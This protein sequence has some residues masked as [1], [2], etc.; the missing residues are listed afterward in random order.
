MDYSTYLARKQQ[1][2]PQLG[3]AK[4][5]RTSTKSVERRAT[6]AA[7][8]VEAR[9]C[10]C[11][12][13]RELEA[14][15]EHEARAILAAMRQDEAAEDRRASEELARF[16]CKL[17]RAAQRER[18][19]AAQALR[20][21]RHREYLA[22]CVRRAREAQRQF[23]LCYVAVPVGERLS[24]PGPL[25]QA[26]PATTVNPEAQ[27]SRQPRVSPAA[28]GQS[29]RKPSRKSGNL[30]HNLAAK[31]VTALALQPDSL[32]VLSAEPE[33]M[34]QPGARYD[35]SDYTQPTRDGAQLSARE[36]RTMD[37]EDL[38]L[39]DESQR[40][41]IAAIEEGTGSVHLPSHATMLAH[42]CFCGSGTGDLNWAS[43][44]VKAN[45][46]AAE[47]APAGSATPER[48]REMVIGFGSASLPP[49]RSG[50]TLLF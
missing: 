19:R 28:V 43:G 14:H 11:P 44:E 47:G 27:T 41:E 9:A 22:R 5:I 33:Q 7:A 38:N 25:V 29:S 23:S 2:V 8:L 45:V 48:L 10:T 12:V 34:D 50:G 4:S 42:A 32:D 49:K 37:R 17:D 35:V 13:D 3:S 31:L 40:N 20:A 16:T 36:D 39:Y 1:P 24:K 46:E 18:R 6:R 15:R 21:T 30:S 26:G